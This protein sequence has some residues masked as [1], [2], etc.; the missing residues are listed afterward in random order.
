M[1]MSEL[2]A[3]QLGSGIGYAALFFPIT[4]F[5]M[6]STRGKLAFGILF[7]TALAVAVV[8]GTTGLLMPQTSFSSSAGLM[9]FFAWPIFVSA[10][11]LHI[12]YKR[13]PT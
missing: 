10:I 7:P 11:A 6:R 8:L 9:M 3:H 4:Y 13:Q 5:A 1:E 12:V 2:I